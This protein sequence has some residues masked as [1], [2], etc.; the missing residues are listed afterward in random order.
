VPD[1]ISDEEAL[2]RL[3]QFLREVQRLLQQINDHPPRLIPGRHHDGM[4]AAWESLQPRFESAIA[5]LAPSTTSNIVPN[6]RLRGLAGAELVFKLEIFAHARD[7]YFDH[8]S[9]K[10][11]RSRGR[12]W[13]SRWRRLLAPTLKAADV[14]LGSL[15]SLF[16][17][18]EAIKEYKEALE[19]GIALGDK[20]D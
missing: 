3:R 11:G 19:V 10:K 5:A 16:P 18:V 7:R 20:R 15:G 9:P 1:D 17:A 8:G 2:R 14:I 12:R 4:N 6:L 13:W